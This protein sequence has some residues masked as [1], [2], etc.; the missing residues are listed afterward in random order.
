[1]RAQIKR[2]LVFIALISA[3]GGCEDQQEH[4]SL[5]LAVLK[6]D[7]V[8]AKAEQDYRVL[9]FASRRLV[10]PGFEDE[11]VKSLKAQCGIRYWKNE[12]DV[13][14]SVTA[15]ENRSTKYEYASK[16]NKAVYALCKQS[17]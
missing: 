12:G 3:L 2:T 10:I 4:G 9:V 17:N 8:Q 11:N 5:G 6:S 7:L 16:Y 13:M 1:M 14:Y 15:R